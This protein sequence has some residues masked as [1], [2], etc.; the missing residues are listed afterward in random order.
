M[1][2]IFLISF[3]IQQEQVCYSTL[4]D[5]TGA[6]FKNHCYIVFETQFL[7][8]LD[9]RGYCKQHFHPLSD[10]V[11]IENNETNDFLYELRGEIDETW[12]GLYAPMAIYWD[13]IVD[14]SRLETGDY[15]N[16]G[17]GEPSDTGFCAEMR[18][19]YGSVWAASDCD[20]YKRFFCS[21]EMYKC[22][23]ISAN[24]QS[25]CSWNGMCIFE[26][27][28]T[29]EECY[30]GYDCEQHY[31]DEIEWNNPQVCNFRHGNC[32]ECNTCVCENEYY[33]Q[34]CYEFIP[35]VNAILNKSVDKIFVQYEMSVNLLGL[36]YE[37]FVANDIVLNANELDLYGKSYF[38]H[39]GIFTSYLVIET[40]EEFLSEFDGLTGIFVNISSITGVNE[41]IS[42][43]IEIVDNTLDSTIIDNNIFVIIV[44]GSVFIAILI[45]VLAT[46]VFCLILYCKCLRKE[47]NGDK[48]YEMMKRENQRNIAKIKINKDLFKIK[49]SEI[50]IIKK[51]GKGGGAQVFLGSWNGQTIAFKC[52]QVDDL[53][54]TRGMFEGFEKEVEFILSVRH[55]NIITYYGCTLE[56]PRVGIVMEF[57]KN[58]DVK[59][60][61]SNN[62]DI[63]FEKRI[64][65][66]R[67]IVAAMIYLHD[68]DVIHRDIKAENVLLDKELVSKLT[69]FGV[70][71]FCKNVEETKTTRVGTSQYMA[72]EICKG[73]GKYSN[74]CDVF[75]F[76][77]LMFEILTSNFNP[78]NKSIA[79]NLELKI[80]SDA[81]FRPNVNEL[82]FLNGSQNEFLIDIITDSWKHTPRS[83]PTFKEINELLGEVDVK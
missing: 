78:F 80:A 50:K 3:A 83:R 76:G 64:E 8:F 30:Y 14:D 2:L 75:S 58:G 18:D 25:V 82:N 45:L 61:F 24:N 37:D 7:S 39:D 21:Y 33:G 72:P 47:G 5:D 48:I 68:R 70:S 4:S 46:I 35:F 12:I 66:L 26:N 62:K 20:N 13:W 59:K 67:G 74:K 16:W 19:W 71:R 31:C 41:V 77:I 52:F 34:Y 63:A 28:C 56:P 54:G 29:C 55:P 17:G 60:Y 40:E 1:F 38:I 23:N 65:I 36:F 22:N 42:L 57:C 73:E 49:Y 53:S 81:N 32:V 51:I 44:S 43:E 15:N 79:F 10:L 6:V 11:K 27:N 9:S 69:D